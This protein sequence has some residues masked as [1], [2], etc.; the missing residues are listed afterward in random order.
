MATESKR[1]FKEL[2]PLEPPAVAERDQSVEDLVRQIFQ[3]ASRHRD[4]LIRFYAWYTG[5][6]SVSIVA[7]IYLQ[8]QARLVE[9]NETLELIPQW[10]L[11]LVIVGM[12]GQ[13]IGLL[14][15]VTKRV[16]EYKPFLEHASKDH[17]TDRLSKS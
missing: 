1:L 5:L 8:A 14:T 16:W 17:K 12:F 4:F 3:Q 13:F 7:L 10:A 9:G 2:R 11:N 6:L 15:I